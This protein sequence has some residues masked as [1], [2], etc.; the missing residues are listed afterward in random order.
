MMMIHILDTPSGYIGIYDVLH[1]LDT[2]S[3]YIG[4]YDVLHI[5]DTPSGYI[6]IYDDDAHT[7]YTVWIYWYT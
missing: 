7:G 5:L 3:G 6:G 1:I 2:P 4:I